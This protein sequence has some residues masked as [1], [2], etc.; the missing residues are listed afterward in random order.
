MCLFIYTR[1]VIRE[2]LDDNCNKITRNALQDPMA[3]DAVIQVHQ[4]IVACVS[5]PEILTTS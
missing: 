1:F 3:Q 5:P 2:I 4:H